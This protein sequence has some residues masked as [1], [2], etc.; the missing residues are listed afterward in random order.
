MGDTWGSFGGAT[1]VTL[2]TIL[3]FAAILSLAAI[4]ELAAILDMAAIRVLV[5]SLAAVG[6]CIKEFKI[7]PCIFALS[8]FKLIAPNCIV[9]VYKFESFSTNV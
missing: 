5:C 2:A 6:W 7:V 4:L 3:D 8:S 1:L 9:C